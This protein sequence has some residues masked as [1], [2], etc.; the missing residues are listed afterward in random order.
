M[1]PYKILGVS[2]SAPPAEIKKAYRKLVLKHHPD[3]GGDEEEFKKINEAYSI[4]SDEAKRAQ[5]DAQASGEAAGF[6]DIFHGGSS[7]FGPGSIF[8]E[9][10]GQQRKAAPRQPVFNLQISLEDIKNGSIR[11]ASYKKQ[12][13]CASCNGFGGKGKK[14]CGMCNGAGMLMIRPAPNVFQQTTCPACRGQGSAFDIKCTPCDGHGS[15]M[16]KENIR[17]KIEEI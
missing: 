1:D 17:F 3:H 12:V 4:L 7:P 10:F 8:E 2:S 16:K 13:K 15:R 5:F 11:I 14:T 9:I 6:R